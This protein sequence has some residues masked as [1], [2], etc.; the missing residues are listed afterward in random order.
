MKRLS[1]KDPAEIVP[2]SWDFTLDLG[3]ATIEGTPVITCAVDRSLRRNNDADTS[4][5]LYGDPQIV[6]R[7]VVQLVRGGTHGVDYKV[8]CGIVPSSTPSALIFKTSVLPV[9]NQ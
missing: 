1:E 2:L 3:E 6:D 9:R 4:D 8:K 5:M 7:V